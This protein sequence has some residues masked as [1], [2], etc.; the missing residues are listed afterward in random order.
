MDPNT[1]GCRR[2]PPTILATVLC[3]LLGPLAPHCASV[4]IRTTGFGSSL[5]RL[6]R[7]LSDTPAGR[8][9]LALSESP[10]AVGGHLAW[11]CI[12]A[13][14]A[15]GGIFLPSDPPQV[16]RETVP[17]P[18]PP[19][20]PG[21]RHRRQHCLRWFSLLARPATVHRAG[22][23]GHKVHGTF[24]PDTS[25][26]PGIACAGVVVIYRSDGIGRFR[27]ASSLTSPLSTIKAE[28][29]S[30]GRVVLSRPSAVLWPPPTSPVASPYTS[31]YGL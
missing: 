8:S 25:W 21:S 4:E 7:L 15:G 6:A 31:P 11:E 18:V 30:S 24:A 5:R 16:P 10:G 22:V 9:G 2:L 28:A 19:P 3:R 27:H 29:L 1:L 14:P 17:R 26:P 13:S 20:L 23:C 12:P